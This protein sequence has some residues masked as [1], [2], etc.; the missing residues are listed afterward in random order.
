MSLN[1]F[2]VFEYRDFKTGEW[3]LAN[4]YS[5]HEEHGYEPAQ[6]IVGNSEKWSAISGRELFDSLYDDEEK[7][8]LYPFNAIECIDRLIE[9]ATT[10][11]IPDDA[12]EGAKDYYGKFCQSPEESFSKSWYKPGCITYTLQDL[13]QI[14]VLA[15]VAS[16]GAKRFYQRHFL[17]IKWLLH[18]IARSEYVFKNSNVRVIIWAT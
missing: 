14:E 4:L 13:S 5:K 11:T 6:L 10:A 7:E 17:E 16:P 3:K 8:I 15:H 9:G 1:T 2:S 18:S 12:S